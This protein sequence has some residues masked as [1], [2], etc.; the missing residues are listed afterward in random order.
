MGRWSQGAL[1]TGLARRLSVVD[2]N[3]VF[4][5]L[6]KVSRRSCVEV[7]VLL[8]VAV[9]ASLL[10][11][12]LVTSRPQPGNCLLHLTHCQHPHRALQGAANPLWLRCAVIR[13]GPFT[14]AYR[15]LIYQARNNSSSFS[16]YLLFCRPPPPLLDRLLFP[17]TSLHA[18]VPTRPQCA[19]STPPTP[20][21]SPSR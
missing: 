8:D 14:T 19:S 7:P 21:T 3:S 2:G 12:I 15:L 11:A 1:A 6:R 5:C 13:G 20:V 18:P 17:S 4:V 10:P 9:S 16:P